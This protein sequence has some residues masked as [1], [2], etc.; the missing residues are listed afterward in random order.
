[1]L[2]DLLTDKNNRITDR[3]LKQPNFNNKKCCVCGFNYLFQD[4]Y[5][6]NLN[7]INLPPDWKPNELIILQIISTIKGD[8]KIFYM[9]KAKFKL[10]LLKLPNW[11]IKATTIATTTPPITI[12]MYLVIANAVSNP[13]CIINAANTVYEEEQ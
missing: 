5:Y 1:M 9:V 4:C 13:L 11:W 3:A 7:G 6:L 10:L 2:G 8:N 12:L